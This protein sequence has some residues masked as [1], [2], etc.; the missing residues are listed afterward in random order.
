MTAPVSRCRRRARSS[1]RTVCATGD[2][3]GAGV[4]D[5]WIDISCFQSAPAGQ[6]GD[7]GVG[8]LLRS[9]LLELGLRA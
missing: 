2:V 1:G 5:V 3:S 8:I 4:D 7:S 9:G 6:F